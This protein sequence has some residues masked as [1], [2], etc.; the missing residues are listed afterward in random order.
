MCKPCTSPACSWDQTTAQRNFWAD[1]SA[2]Q[3]GGILNSELLA[4]SILPAPE[5]K[6][7]EFSTHIPLSTTEKLVL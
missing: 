7:L 5:A 2:S 6:P 3:R 1:G 4:N